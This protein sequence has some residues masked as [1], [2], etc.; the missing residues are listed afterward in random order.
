MDEAIDPYLQEAAAFSGRNT[1]VAS[2]PGAARYT[3]SAWAG[4]KVL[5]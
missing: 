2:E 3:Q 5:R 1:T 4:F